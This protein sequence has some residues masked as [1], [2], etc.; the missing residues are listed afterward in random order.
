MPDYS[1]GKI[2][3]IILKGVKLEDA[4]GD[5]YIGSTANMIRR[6]SK[7]FCDFKKGT[8]TCS[9]RNLFEKYG[10]DNCEFIIL[11][12]YP[13]NSRKELSIREQVYIT[14]TRCVNE[15]R[16]FVDTEIMKNE[17]KV[18]DVNYRM[19]NIEKKTAYEKQY[20]KEHQSEKKA[21]DILF[22]E[23]NKDKIKQRLA[24]V[25]VCE[26]GCSINRACMWNHKKTNK[27]ATLVEALQQQAQACP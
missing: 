2:Y 20:N 3:A 17:K 1:K 21:Y 6:K 13:C 10:V 15:K 8:S 26:C 18:Y 7:H 9:S 23:K 5:V 4:E 19:D 11:Q 12:D 14:T 24:E 22:R 27:H 16:A 25:I